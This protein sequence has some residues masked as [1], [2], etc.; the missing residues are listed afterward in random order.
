MPLR[1]WYYLHMNAITELYPADTE[2]RLERQNKTWTIAVAAA[3][4]ILFA[5]C[6]IL[7]VLTNTANASSMELIVCLI[8]LLG[9]W[10]VIFCTARFII[11]GRRELAHYHN[12]Q[13]EPRQTVSGTVTLDPTRIAIKGSIVVQTLT[14]R[15]GE[16]AQR[17]H[18]NA[19]KTSLLPDLP[20]ELIIH[21]AHGYA[22]AWEVRDAAH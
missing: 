8:S 11:G 19:K 17:V 20:A 15:N 14:V 2:A 16:K 5:A 1:P 10:V 21:T 3:A 12:L 7:C 22:V 6:V 13:N 4:L 18:I 9:G